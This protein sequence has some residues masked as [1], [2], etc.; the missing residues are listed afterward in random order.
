M[1]SVDYIINSLKIASV[2]IDNFQET[3]DSNAKLKK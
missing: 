3:N 2:I 1:S